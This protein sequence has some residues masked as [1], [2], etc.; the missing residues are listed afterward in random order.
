Q[1][2]RALT[3]I[4]LAQPVPLHG[5]GLIPPAAQPLVQVPQ[6]LFQVLGIRLCRYPVDPRRTVFAR[7][8]IRLAPKVHVH[9][10]SQRR[11][12]HLWR[13]LCLLGNPL[14]LCCDGWG[15]RS[16]SHLSS[17]SN[18]M[19][20]LA[21]PPVGRLGLTSPPSAVLCS[22]KTARCPSWVASRPLASQYPVCSLGLCP[23][24]GSLGSGSFHPAPGLLV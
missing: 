17:Q 7:P 14:E 11:K 16:I 22:A 15:S 9:Q 20:G 24:T 8:V 2:Y 3:P 23:L 12:D 18:G 10:V 13:L 4:G 21:F 1:P 6:V 5:R 19:P